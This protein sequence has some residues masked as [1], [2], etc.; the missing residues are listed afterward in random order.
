MITTFQKAF[1]WFTS[2]W[3]SSSFD[4]H[5]QLYKS[6][7]SCSR[8]IGSD[9]WLLRGHWPWASR[10]SWASWALGMIFFEKKSIH[11]RAS[12]SWWALDLNLKIEI[13]QG[14]SVDFPW[15]CKGGARCRSLVFLTKAWSVAETNQTVLWALAQKKGTLKPFKTWVFSK[16]ENQQ[17][18]TR[19]LFSRALADF[20][21]SQAQ[22]GMWHIRTVRKWKVWLLERPLTSRPSL[23]RSSK[24]GCWA[25]LESTNFG[26]SRRCLVG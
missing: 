16:T 6:M 11:G 15:R 7:F 5:P 17:K 24:V 4:P 3:N 22:L 2:S 26:S 1:K 19:S 14:I 9:R 13:R 25:L 21:W 8:H 18:H 20:F 12:W 10:A 23:R